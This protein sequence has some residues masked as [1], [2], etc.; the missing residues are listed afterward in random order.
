[1]P[2]KN[3]PSIGFASNYSKSVYRRSGNFTPS[4][5]F[6]FAAI[7]QNQL[8]NFL[9]RKRLKPPLNKTFGFALADCVFSFRNPLSESLKLTAGGELHSAPKIS[10]L[11]YNLFCGLSSKFRCVYITFI[12]FSFSDSFSISDL[13]GCRKQARRRF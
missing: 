13:R 8:Q 6:V 11:F 7:P 3:N 5:R 10:A 1:M 12:T 2:P 4:K 9:S